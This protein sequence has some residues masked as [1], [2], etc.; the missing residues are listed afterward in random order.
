MPDYSPPESVRKFWVDPET[1]PDTASNESVSKIRG[2][3]P[4]LVKKQCLN[5]FAAYGI[6]DDDCFASSVGKKVWFSSL[7]VQEKGKSRE[8][9]SV[10]EVV[11]DKC[12]R[13]P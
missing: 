4:D 12:K 11:V 1:L 9:T 5:T 8:A 7:N 3:V 13:K 6:G 2:N 10:A